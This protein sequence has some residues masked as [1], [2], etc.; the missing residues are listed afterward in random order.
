MCY[1]AECTSPLGMEYGMIWNYQITSSSETTA[2]KK[3]WGRLNSI[4][5]CA[6][7]ISSVA[8]G[9]ELYH[10]IQI[11]LLETYLVR[12]VATQGKQT[13][14]PEM[15][16]EGVTSFFFKYSL[17]GEVWSRYHTVCIPIFH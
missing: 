6:D 9:K 13:D 1:H 15:Q 14:N 5:W 10:Y 16:A 11:D 7:V 8:P 17:K 12:G 2:N 4:G 3:E